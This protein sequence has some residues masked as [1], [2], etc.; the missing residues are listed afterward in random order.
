M[1]ALRSTTLEQSRG[2]KVRSSVKKLCDGCKVC[3]FLIVRLRPTALLQ[4]RSRLQSVM[5][6]PWPMVFDFPFLTFVRYYVSD[7]RSY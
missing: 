4:R 6:E 3:P 5:D 7:E 2:M 1:D